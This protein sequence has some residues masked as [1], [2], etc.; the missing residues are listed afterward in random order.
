MYEGYLR[1]KSL[2]GDSET[3]MMY[4]LK[5]V[6]KK[7]AELEVPKF[8]E[9]TGFEVITSEGQLRLSVLETKEER[10]GWL[11]MEMVWTCAGGG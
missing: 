7:E 4:G 8:S 3:C 1:Q 6:A 11:G 5:M 2:Q 10:P 9:G